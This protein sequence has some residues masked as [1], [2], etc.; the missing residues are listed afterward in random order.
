[1]DV[2]TRDLAADPGRILEEALKHPVTITGHT[3]SLVLLSAQEYARLKRR[4]RLVLA[5]EDM[6]EDFLTE[7]RKPFAHPDQDALDGLLDG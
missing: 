1:M 6:P 3:G 4:E 7:L 5:V 2:T